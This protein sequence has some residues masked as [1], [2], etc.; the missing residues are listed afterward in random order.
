MTLE[1]CCEKPE[2]YKAVNFPDTP[3]NRE[4]FKRAIEFNEKIEKEY[5]RYLI[6]NGIK[7][8]FY[9][10]GP[11]DGTPLVWSH[12]IVS[13]GVSFSVIAQE[14]ASAGYRVLALD[15][16]GHGNTRITDYSFTI[17]D[18][19]DDIKGL[20]DFLSIDKAVMGGFLQGEI[21]RAHV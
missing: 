7:L 14:L 9:D 12:G 20:M 15:H 19:A 13:N 18:M 16:R 8:F 17:Y 11:K 4:L 2:T 21:G 3:E 6:V 10:F 1:E 5:G